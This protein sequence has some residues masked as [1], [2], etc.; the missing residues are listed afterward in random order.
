M[1]AGICLPRER[2]WKQDRAMFFLD[3]LPPRAGVV[4]AALP[5]EDQPLMDKGGEILCER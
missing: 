4:V 5:R 1:G 3:S 2:V